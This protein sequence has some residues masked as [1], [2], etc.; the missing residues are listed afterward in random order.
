MFAVLCMCVWGRGVDAAV[1]A[2][3][4]VCVCKS[5]WFQLLWVGISRE[6]EGMSMC[7]CEPSSS[8]C[9]VHQIGANIV[10]SQT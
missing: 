8:R 7:C 5:L 9:D 4:C 6:G 3:K 1:F 10:A 2:H